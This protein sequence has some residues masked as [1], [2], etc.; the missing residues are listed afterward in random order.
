MPVQQEMRDRARHRV[1]DGDGGRKGSGRFG[2]ACSGSVVEV[3]VRRRGISGSG[4][5][6]GH[7]L[8]GGKLGEPMKLIDG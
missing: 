6:R 4:V 3:W 2:F 5:G 1:G 7:M 8:V